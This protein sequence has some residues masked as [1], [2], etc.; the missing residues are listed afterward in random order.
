MILL[1]K[2]GSNMICMYRRVKRFATSSDNANGLNRDARQL[3]DH[4]PVKDDTFISNTMMR[5]H[6]RVRQYDECV[7]LYR[8]LRGNVA[9]KPDGYTFM[10][11]GKLCALSLDVWGSQQVHDLVV[12]EGFEHDLWTMHINCLMKWLY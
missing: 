4:M 12:K 5:A 3:F 7:G 6:L 1:L 9:F 2:K 11:L 8:E 10:T